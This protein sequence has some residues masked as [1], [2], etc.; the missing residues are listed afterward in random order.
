[1]LILAI[2]AASP[3]TKLWL[4]TSH[5]PLTPT[6]EWESGRNLADELLPALMKL[7]NDTKVNLSDLSGIVLYAGPGSFTSLRIG[8]SVA[9]AL[10]SSLAIP[11][12]S[13]KA[14]NW[15]EVGL[16]RLK[17]SEND[18]IALPFYGSEANVTKPKA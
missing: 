15:L 4:I 9:N 6:L 10:A 11:V 7:L 13:E 18:R 16:K 14:E 1:M 12:I 17:G 3:V 5:I 2:E 8:H